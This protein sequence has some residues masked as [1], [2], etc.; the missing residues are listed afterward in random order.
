M[1]SE[2]SLFW[3][4]LCARNWTL[5]LLSS[6]PRPV[7]WGGL[8]M[9]YGWFGRADR[10]AREDMCREACLQQI[11][12]HEHTVKF[13]CIGFTPSSW[14]FFMLT[15]HYW[16][17]HSPSTNKHILCHVSSQV[18]RCN[19]QVQQLRAQFSQNTRSGVCCCRAL[20]FMAF[21]GRS[22]GQKDLQLES[23]HFHYQHAATCWTSSNFS[24]NCRWVG[25]SQDV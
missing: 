5:K 21:L 12:G 20:M 14:T 17:I 3:D 13:K 18:Q 25:N 24:W 11:F 9:F 7:W 6:I 4:I 15:F 19:E 22:E 1:L 16:K 10:R 8:T 2:A 23:S